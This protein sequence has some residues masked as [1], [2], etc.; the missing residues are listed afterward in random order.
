M[1]E[2]MNLPGAARADVAIEKLTEYCL[3]PHHPRGRHKARLFWSVLGL[4]FRHA[5]WLRDAL[6]EAARAG[7]AKASERDRYGQRYVLDF[8][9]VG[10]RG[11][12]GIRSLWI[13]RVGEDI[14]RLTSCYVLMR[15]QGR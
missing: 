2:V 15:R 13:V 9:M 7:E 6:I 3:N 4:D 5:I 14:P 8:E 10:P 12:A 1:G 11:S